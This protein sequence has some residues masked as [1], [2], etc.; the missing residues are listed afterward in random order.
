M[1]REEPASMASH[2]FAYLVKVLQKV[3]GDARQAAYKSPHTTAQ[4][5][6]NFTP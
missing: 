1:L 6:L 2:S 3:Y 5:S 4:P